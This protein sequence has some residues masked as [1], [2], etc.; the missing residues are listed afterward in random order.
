L[1]NILILG[2]GRVGSSVA[3]QLV[4]ERYNVTVLDNDPTLL[5][6]LADRLDLRTIVGLANNPKALIAAGIQDTDLLLAVTPYD[7]VNMVAC[8]IAH[9][10]FNVPTRLA[11]I[12]DQDILE[13]AG[14]FSESGFA[15]NHVI[16]PAQIVTDY[17]VSLIETPEAL[18]VLEFADGLAKMIAVRVEAG[19]HIDGKDLAT[20]AIYLDEI[21]CRVVSIYRKNKRVRP[22]GKVE[23][24]VGDEVFF[25]VASSDV[26]R[27]VSEFCSN[28]KAVK[29]V[30]ICG[31]GNV[32]YR[33]A[34]QIEARYQVKVIEM[35]RDRAHWLAEHLSDSLV[36][37]GEAT[38]ED[39]LENEQIDRC[40]LFLAL[41][42]DDEDNIMSSLLAKQMGARRVVSIINR[43]RYVDLLQ[44]G[45]ID[46]ALSPAQV[47]IGALLAHVRQGDIVAVHSLRRGEAE[48]IELIVHG[49]QDTSKVVGRKIEDIKLPQG[50]D[51]AALVRGKQ[52]I[53]AH[54]DTVIQSDDHVIVFIDNKSHIRDIEKLF[55]VS[56]GF[57]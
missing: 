6:P 11:R 42:S 19:A 49:T 29:R 41:T 31:G 55:A 43:S 7:E 32:G 22:D 27:V 15:I 1:P 8:K 56:V 40:D 38:D 24:Q 5:K 34:K 28:D 37:H 54:H 20:L 30:Q 48:A 44:G 13:Y 35:N 10:L 52:V 23:L 51:L 26:R 47:T 4:H 50:A 12:R 17:L 57:F 25:L 18:Q 21:D 45:K 16:T 39:L 9:D 36:L 3:E 46:V 53:M 14:L 33:L 2:A